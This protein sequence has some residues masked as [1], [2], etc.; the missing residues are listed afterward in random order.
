[1]N[2]VETAAQRAEVTA[3]ESTIRLTAYELAGLQMILPKACEREAC[4]CHSVRAKV[5]AALDALKAEAMKP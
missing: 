4:W 3:P 1:M 2:K 5:H